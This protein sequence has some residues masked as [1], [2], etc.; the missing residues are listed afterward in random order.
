MAR[1]NHRP[2][3]S[4]QPKVKTLSMLFQSTLKL[5][6]PAAR[7]RLAQKIAFLSR[8]HHACLIAF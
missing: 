2:A 3:L 6:E 8:L 4:H 7:R 5:I 1:P